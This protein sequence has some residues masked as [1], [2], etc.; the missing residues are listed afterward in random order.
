MSG[1]EKIIIK[2]VKK[3]VFHSTH[4]GQWKVA[5]AD[6]VT[7]MMAFFLLLWLLSMVSQEK[8]AV[9]A[10]YFKHFSIFQ[11][12]GMSI[13]DGKAFV[14]EDF[15]TRPEIR[16]E[17]FGNKLK[18][19]VEEKL[20]DMKDQVL[21]DVI[22]GG[23][24][25]QIVD[26]EGNPMFRLGSAEPTVKAKEV[27]ALIYEN[28]KDMKQKIAIEGHTDAAPFRGDQI[29]NWELATSRASAARRE[30]EQHGIEPSRI[31]RV[32]GYADQELLIKEDPRDARN[33]RI[34]IILLQ[35]HQPA[36]PIRKPL[37]DK[38]GMRAGVTGQPMQDVLSEKVIAQ[39]DPAQDVKK[40]LSDPEKQAPS[41]IRGIRNLKQKKP[42]RHRDV[43]GVRD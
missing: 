18:R 30:L 5:Y 42:V 4:G 1:S 19:N 25:I 23:V 26:K 35:E 7:A 6:F 33:R 17:E 43:T 36:T 12:S 27:L 24:R 41:T 3:R 32:V 10:E 37:E 9:L 8:R 40:T 28:V 16:P 34:S 21:V 20:K 14:M 31:A 29:T 38:H 22:E 15:I 39:G 11:E 13:L 2:K